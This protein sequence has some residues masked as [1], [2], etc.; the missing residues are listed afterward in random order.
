MGELFNNILDKDEQVL[1][2]FK[3][4]KL[5]MFFSMFFRGFFVW[6]WFLLLLFLEI[7]VP[8]VD[9]AGNTIEGTPWGGIIALSVLVVLLITISV[10]CFVLE[11]KK[12]FYAYTN[13]RVVIRRGIIGVDFKSLD[14]NMIGAVTVNVTLLDKIVRKNTGTIVFGS[15]ASPIS[16]NNFMFKFAHIVNPYETYKEIKNVIDDFKNKPIA[17]V[18]TEKAEEKPAKKATT[19]KATTKTETAKK[20]TTKKQTKVDESKKS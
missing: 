15:M 12:T 8:Q 7:F 20:Q 11:Y 13:K 19:K 1:K 17:E 5:K 2:I 4:N 3:P 18:K 16:Q 10:V 6:L 14:M 9:E